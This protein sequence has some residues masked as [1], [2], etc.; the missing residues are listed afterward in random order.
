M[1]FPVF[2]LVDAFVLAAQAE[3]PAVAEVAVSGEGAELEDGQAARAKTA[4]AEV[5]RV[6]VAV[7]RSD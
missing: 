7:G 1:A 4:P 3:G 2:H 5:L 6:A